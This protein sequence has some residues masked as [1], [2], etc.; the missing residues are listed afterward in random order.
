MLIIIL[1]VLFLLPPVSYKIDIS[2]DGY[3][4]QENDSGFSIDIDMKLKGEFDRK[5]KEFRGN[6][7]I[8]G[9]DY[10]DCRISSNS[11]FFCDSSDSPI[12]FFGTSFSNNKFD[13]ITLIITDSPLYSQLIGHEYTEDIII[14]IPSE[15]RYS[16]LKLSAKLK[17]QYLNR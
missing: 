7:Y 12:Q 8:N 9:V 16:S 2:Y 15:D 3:G 1:A 13:E 4:Y 11:G 6:V 10:K 14:S 5:A 17:N